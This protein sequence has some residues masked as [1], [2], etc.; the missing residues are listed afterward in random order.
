M[1][2]SVDKPVLC[3]QRQEARFD[4]CSYERQAEREGHVRPEPAS[5]PDHLH[6]GSRRRLSLQGCGSSLLPSL[7]RPGRQRWPDRQR[8]LGLD[9]SRHGEG[10]RHDGA[11]RQ[12]GF[13]RYFRSRESPVSRELAHRHRGLPLAGYEGLSGP[14]FYCRGPFPGARDAGLRFT[15]APERDEPPGIFGHG[16]VYGVSAPPTTSPSTSGADLPMR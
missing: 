12:H 16:A 11:V 8:R 9:G 5:G 4:S 7:E 10:I 15:A 14:C 6:P 3:L 13:R 1:S 2:L